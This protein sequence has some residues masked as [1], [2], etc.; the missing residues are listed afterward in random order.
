MIGPRVH[1]CLRGA[2]SCV[3][4]DVSS[5][6]LWK[7]PKHLGQ[8]A[9]EPVEAT[10]MLLG[11]LGQRALEPV[12]ASSGLG[13]ELVNELIERVAVVLESRD[14]ARNAGIAGHA[15]HATCQSSDMPGAVYAPVDAQKAGARSRR[16]D[17]THGDSGGGR[18]TSA[19]FS[20][21]SLRAGLRSLR[22]R[23]HPSPCPH[24]ELSERAGPATYFGVPVYDGRLRCRQKRRCSESSMPRSAS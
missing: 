21:P 14:T 20:A 2:E 18:K 15:A 11:H 19:G 3:L 4:A 6:R 7:A 9:L 5:E 13:P 1:G 17:T 16:C 23:V 10:R 24:A 12:E 22:T 8:C